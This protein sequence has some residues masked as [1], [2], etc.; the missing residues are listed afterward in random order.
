[1]KKD[2]ARQQELVRM[3]KTDDFG[4]RIWGIGDYYQ[5]KSGMLIETSYLLFSVIE[6]R[7]NK[8]YLPKQQHA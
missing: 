2:L 6:Y 1:M 4:H 5:E 7:L 8:A 3:A